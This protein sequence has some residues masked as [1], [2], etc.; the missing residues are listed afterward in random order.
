[1]SFWPEALSN[2]QKLA[3]AMSKDN[4]LIGKDL[5]IFN[6]AMLA[7]AK[8]VEDLRAG[9]ITPEEVLLALDLDLKAIA[10]V[11]PPAATI[12]S[13]VEAGAILVSAF[14]YFGIIKVDHGKPYV[15]GS[16]INPNAGSGT[17]TPIGV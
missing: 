9:T 16:G 2:L 15:P 5:Q 14:D 4:S 12:D 17:D 1:M 3:Q 7:T 8:A 11:Y 13:Y 10:I 6:T